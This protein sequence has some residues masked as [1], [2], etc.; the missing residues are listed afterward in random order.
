MEFKDYYAILGVE[1]AASDADIKARYRKLARKYH[2]DV[3]K[4][5]D[6]EDK[7]KELGEA[8]EV[9]KDPE[10]RAEYDELRRYG[11]NVGGEFRPPPGWH[12]A[13][14]FSGGGYT[15]ADAQHFSDFFE[16]I[17]GAAGVEPG[18]RGFSSGR[19]SSGRGHA[20]FRRRGD[21]VQHTLSLFLE[22]AHAGGQRQIKLTI[23]TIDATGRAV[24]REKTLNV[25]IPAGVMPGQ[26]IRLAGQGAPGEGGA[27]AGD[28]F[29]EV[30]F[31][32]HPR[33]SVDGRNIVFTLP[34]TASEAALGTT[35]EVPTLGG[36]VKLRIPKNSSS[37]DKLRLKGK[38][39][40][41][42]TPGD[43]L[44]VL[45]VVLPKHHSEA[46][47]TLYRQLAEQESDFDPRAGE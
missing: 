21:D 47:A 37:G 8:Y 19:E 22:E 16:S 38:G 10:K 15:G 3:S 1:E 14:G 41:G 33:F 20:V 23:P 44:V 9:L 25:K 6:A 32:P 18:R 30:E 28:L 2:P 17:F 35:V 29:L 43:Q 36:N 11:A 26:R 39:L 46:A 7:F 24:P 34:L 31:A 13:A 12:S 42:D 4:D 27:P 45:K 40:A 5:A